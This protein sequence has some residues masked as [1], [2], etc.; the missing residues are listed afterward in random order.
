MWSRAS[1]I[2]WLTW[3]HMVRLWCSDFPACRVLSVSPVHIWHSASTKVD[4][5]HLIKSSSRI[6]LFVPFSIPCEAWLHPNLRKWQWCSLSHFEFRVCVHACVRLTN[7]ANHQ[8]PNLNHLGVRSKQWTCIMDWNCLSVT[9][10][11]QIVFFNLI[12]WLKMNLH[13]SS[14]PAET[15]L[16]WVETCISTVV[17]KC[18]E[19]L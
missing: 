12:V 17:L 1:Q 15:K 3:Q 16:R 10:F 4:K 9:D 6:V 2:I 18:Q 5:M 13:D 19:S 14:L 8:A 11:Q 7:S